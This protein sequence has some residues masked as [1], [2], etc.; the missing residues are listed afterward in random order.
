M[1]DEYLGHQI[2]NY[3]KVKGISQRDFAK[4]CNINETT[5]SKYISGERKPKSDTIMVI[6]YRLGIST[7]ELLG[8]NE[9]YKKAFMEEIS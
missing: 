2:L 5:L 4:L 7:D 8:M 9:Y 1:G 6:A 3:L